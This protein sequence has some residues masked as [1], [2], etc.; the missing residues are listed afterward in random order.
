MARGRRWTDEENKLIAKMYAEGASVEE[1]AEKLPP[2][3]SVIAT[4]N[5]IA[6]LGLRRG[7][8]AP[9]KK[10][11]GAPIECSEVLTREEAL[12]VLA[13]AVKRIQAGGELEEAEIRRL[14]AVATLVRSYFAVFDSFEK[15]AE[16][17]ERVRRLE[18]DAAK[19]LEKD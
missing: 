7:I 5:Q 17:E 1:I 9:M 13:G 2:D 16:L 4:R 19:D 14:R 3:R 18:E 10:F 11:F 8:D 12:K 15:Y 6:R